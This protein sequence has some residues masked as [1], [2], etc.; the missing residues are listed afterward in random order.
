MP[1]SSLRLEGRS[2]VDVRTIRPDEGVRPTFEAAASETEVAHDETN[3][4][5]DL[6]FADLCFF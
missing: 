4:A 2:D 5:A 1:D 6:D 3:H